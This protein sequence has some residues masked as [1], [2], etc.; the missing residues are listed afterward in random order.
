MADVAKKITIKV[1]VSFC[2]KRTIAGIK[3]TPKINNGEK[4][5]HF[6]WLK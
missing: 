2:R 6:G 5:K 3:S 1:P 4:F